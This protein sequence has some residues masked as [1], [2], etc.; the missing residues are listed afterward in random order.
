MNKK[1]LFLSLLAVT[2]LTPTLTFAADSSDFCKMVSKLSAVTLTVGGSI[3]AIGWVIAGILYLTAA[4]GS[5]METAKKAM[6]AS[7]IGTV[8]VILASSAVPLIKSAIGDVGGGGA[9]PAADGL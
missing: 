1:T 3:V 4:G 9:C 6:I 7:I 5:R 2:F 8:L